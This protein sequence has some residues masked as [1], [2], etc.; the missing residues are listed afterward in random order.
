[1]SSAFSALDPPTPARLRR[2]RLVL[3]ALLALAVL[4][5]G[6]GV[7]S[8]ARKVTT[9]QP[10]GVELRGEGNGWTVVSAAP[11]SELLTGDRLVLVNGEQ[12]LTRAEVETQL[13]RRAVAELMVERGDD[14]VIASHPL[15]PLDVDFSYLVLTV[16]AVVYLFI[17]LYILRRGASRQSALFTLWCLA[18]AGVYLLTPV[19]PP[20][21]SIDRAIYVIDEMAR[22]LLPPL[23]LHFFLIFPQPLAV[24]TPFERWARRLIPLLYAPSAALFAFQLDLI[25]TGGAVFAG[26]PT[27]TRILLIDRLVLSLLVGYAFCAVAALIAH[28]QRSQRWEQG[29]QVMWIAVGLAAGYLPFLGLYLLPTTAGFESTEL[30]QVLAVLPLALVPLSFAYA[31]LRYRLWDI[32]VIVRDITTY[33]LTLLL[34]AVGFSLLNLVIRRGIPEDFTLTRNLSTLAGG[35]VIAGLLLPTKQGIQSTLQR[36]QY[37]GSFGRRRALSQFGHELLHERDL[38]RLSTGLL[39]EL[40]ESMDLEHCNLYLV[41]D[42]ALAPVIETPSPLGESSLVLDALDPEVWEQDW[43]H[44]TGVS[45]LPELERPVEQALFLLGYRTAFPLTVRGRRVGLAVAGAK[46][47]DVP[48]NSDDTLLIRQLLNQ[49]ALAIENAQLLEQ[50]QRQ[51]R[52]VIELKKFNEE[53][54]ESSPAGLAV[55]D[56]DNRI[57][58]ANLAFAALV[59]SERSALRRRALSDVLD[60]EALPPADGGMIEATFVDAL[61]RERELQLSMAGFVGDRTSPLHVLV[62]NDVTELAAMERAL[63]EKERL[64]ALGV[65]AAGVAHEVNTPLTGISSYAQMLL[66]RTPESD[67]DHAILRKIERQTFRAAR[68]VNSLLELS[69]ASR[70]NPEPVDLEHVL[71]ECFELLEDRLERHGVSLVREGF[72]Q[73][74]DL[75]VHG[76]G[77][78]LQQVFTNLLLNAIEALDG[79]PPA[80]GGAPAVR[81][82]FEP[83]AEQVTVHVLDNGPGVAR[84]HLGQIFQPFFSTKTDS[85][86]TGLGLSISYEILRRHGGDLSAVNEL[87]GGCRFTVSLPRRRPPRSSESGAVQAQTRSVS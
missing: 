18:S 38:E 7:L 17:G 56:G 24:G 29:R 8:F 19:I 73:G 66:A 41:E 68:I 51:L 12:V 46:E 9:F 28:L 85:G 40:E 14:L 37:R 67:P 58:A 82:A 77:G 71:G 76:N 27:P 30:M 63:E 55:L 72:G 48:L 15:P 3:V 23:T 80:D 42:D 4:V 45:G 78:E 47:G 52:E 86:G 65:M 49:A 83:A 44:L 5:V 61:G 22:L 43:V 1:M 84:E 57:V 60:L 20:A 2:E 74:L 13:R 34:G 26:A 53:I 87:G 69:R 11:G 36:F 64:A 59:G 81:V 32:S 21:D 54:I 6:L 75:T 33:T 10:S 25:F 79:H 31:I 39:Q 62:A 35:L 50:M 70:P 16:I